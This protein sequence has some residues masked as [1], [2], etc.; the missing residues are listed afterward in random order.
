MCPSDTYRVWKSGQCLR[1]DTTLMGFEQMTWQRGKRSFIFR[2]QGQRSNFTC[3]SMCCVGIYSTYLCT[4][5]ASGLI[6]N[7]TVFNLCFKL[8]CIVSLN[9]PNIVQTQRNVDIIQTE[10]CDL[11]LSLFFSSSYVISRTQV[12]TAI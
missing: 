10:K 5:S 8:Y 11:L 6:I 12:F 3:L 9:A 2:G 4:I 7:D 1:V